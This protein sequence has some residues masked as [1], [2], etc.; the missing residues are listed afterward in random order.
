MCVW[1]GGIYAPAAVFFFFL[2]SINLSRSKYELRQTK[3][4]T[5]TSRKWRESAVGDGVYLEGGFIRW[6][7]VRGQQGKMESL[8]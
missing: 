6:T 7:E 4:I 5:M 2:K 8:E 3:Q 1:G